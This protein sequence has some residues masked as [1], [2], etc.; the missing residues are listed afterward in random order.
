MS[1]PSAPSSIATAASD[2]DPTPASTMTG[3]SA[4]SR[5]M[6]RL[7]RFCTPSPEPI[8]GAQGHHGGR[9]GRG[10]LAADDRVVVRVGEDDEP[11]VGQH[12]RRR[13]QCLVVRKERSLVADD[14]QLHPVREPR[15]PAQPGG[16]DRL[17][18][19]VAAGRVRQQRVAVG[20]DVVEQRGAVAG[21]EIDA[22]NRH[23]HHLGPGGVVRAAHRRRGRRTCRCRRSVGSGRFVPAMVRRSSSICSLRALAGALGVC[24][25]ERLL[26]RG[27]C[28]ADSW[29][30]ALSLRRRS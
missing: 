8:G 6:V 16:A 30:R 7:L 22:A 18:G 24:A 20:V 13:Q 15:R 10:Q 19:G 2:G 29:P 23:R 11:L 1:T 9:A 28:G 25:R 26:R 3:T 21:V 4:C 27:F 17:V 14:L 12:A 5:M